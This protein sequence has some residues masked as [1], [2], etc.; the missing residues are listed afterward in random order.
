MD[1]SIQKHLEEPLTDVGVL[2]LAAD[3]IE[4]RGLERHRFESPD[5]ALCIQGAINVACG[6]EPRSPFRLRQ[7]RALTL[8][9]SHLNEKW[10]HIWIQ[11]NSVSKAD[12][13]ALMRKAAA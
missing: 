12:V 4:A 3:L 8:L 10:A 13:V 2:L 6:E 5:G 9:Q 11:D 7:G 1:G